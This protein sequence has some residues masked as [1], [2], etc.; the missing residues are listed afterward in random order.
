MAAYLAKF[1]DTRLIRYLFA[2]VGAL[3]VDFGSFLGFLALGMLAAPASAL[4]YSFGILAHWVL[5]SRTVFNDTVAQRGRDRTRQKALFVV[6]ALIGLMLTIG[7]VGGAD[8]VGIDPRLAKMAAI[9]ASFTVTWFLRAK[10]VFR[11]R[12]G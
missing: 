5:S 11:A 1:R 8:A 10:I 7:I 2:S 6:S 4:G 12:A 9:V 3:A